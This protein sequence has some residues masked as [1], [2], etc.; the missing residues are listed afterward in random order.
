MMREFYKSKY[1]LLMM[2]SAEN[3]IKFGFWQVK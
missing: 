3:A 1:R 2:R